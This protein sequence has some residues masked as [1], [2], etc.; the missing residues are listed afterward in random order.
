MPGEADDRA[1]ELFG[2]LTAG[3]D[4]TL[5]DVDFDD[6]IFAQPVAGTLDD[7][8]T[9]LTNNDLTTIALDG[10]GT[11]DVLMR[12]LRIHLQREFEANRITGDQYAKVYIALTEGAMSQAVQYL[13]IRDTTYW[14]AAI[15]QQQ[16]LRAQAE[17]ITARVQL[18]VAKA[19]LAKA[20][21]GA[22]NEKAQYALAKMK[23]AT[24]DVAYDTAE[25]NLENIMPKQGL[26]LDT[27][28]EEILK[29]IEIKDYNLDTLMPKQGL[30]LDAQVA[31]ANKDTAIKDYNLVTILPKQADLL[32]AQE[33]DMTKETEVKDYNLDFILPAQKNLITEQMESQRAQTMDTRS[34]GATA[35]VGVLGK[36]K[37]LY[38]QQ[39]TSY[40]RD[41]EVKAAKLFTDA[42]I[43]M[44]TIDEGLL[45]PDGFENANIDLILATLVTNNDLS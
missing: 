38:T 43:T 8:I 9:R 1:I 4:F 22:L 27:Q 16:A 39:I 29:D 33:A 2:L 20:Q 18:E 25:Y 44:K 11:F 23:L 32:D 41:S 15:A 5:P 26:M 7:P 21:I 17:V 24:E 31:G 42:W 40:Q 37:D 45:A 34:D 14:Q 35:V 19:E 10:T 6:P 30:M 12:A 13:S 28:K 36:Q 3:E